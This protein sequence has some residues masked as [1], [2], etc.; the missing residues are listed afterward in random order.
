MIDGITP[1]AN[2]QQGMAIYRK[3]QASFP[4]FAAGIWVD[5]DPNDMTHSEMF[6][7]QPFQLHE[8]REWLM[9]AEVGAGWQDSAQLWEGMAMKL[10]VEQSMVST[11]KET[12][13]SQVMGIQRAI[14]LGEVQKVV[15]TRCL[16]VEKSLSATSIWN[17]FEALHEAYPSAFVF[18]LLHPRWGCW[19]GASPEILLESRDNEAR[20][21]SLAG[22]LTIE[23]GGWTEKEAKEQSVTSLFIQDVLNQQGITAAEE[24][25]VNELTMGN[26]KHLHSEW[27]FA[28]HPSDTNTVLELLEALHPTP[29]VG[30]YPKAPA[31]SWL[32]KN[33]SLQRALYTGYLGLMSSARVQLYVTLRCVQLFQNGYTL[34]AGC[35]VNEGSDPEAEW[36]ETTAKMA[37]L[38]KFF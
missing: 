34:Y 17:A 13:Y 15:A 25:P 4:E 22:T 3:P 33:E 16:A 37:L 20:T 36:N 26:I 21:M 31:L 23:Q 1:S 28:L 9:A 18:L 24:S 8:Q 27:Q 38:G 10:P 7:L 12:F 35:G 19:L 6:C 32:A 11:V 2:I 29:A 5:E 30:G 14:H